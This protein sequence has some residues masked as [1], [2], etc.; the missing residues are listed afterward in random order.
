MNPFSRDGA[1]PAVDPTGATIHHGGSVFQILRPL[2][3][4]AIVAKIV[5][6]GAW[7]FAQRGA[8]LILFFGPDPFVLYALFVPSAQGLCRV[9]THFVTER[10]AV[11]LTIDDGPDENDTPQILDLLD[12]YR[13][14]ATFFVIGERAARR[15]DLLREIV[16]RGHQIGHHTHTHPAGS[17][18]C[19]SRHRLSVELDRT[20]DVLRDAGVRPEFFRAPVGIKHLFLGHALMLRQLQ[21]VGWTIRSGDCHSPSP[22]Q[23]VAGIT[24]RLRPG[25]ILLLHEG[26]SVPQPVRVKGIALLLEALA[27]RDLVCEIPEANQ[28]R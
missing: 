24:H 23:L 25:V 15:P 13:A 8:A 3:I 26:P 21:C 28:L 10:R 12:Q 11:W 5:A 17:F 16:R 14:R 4:T 18:W 20:L 6:V 7:A 2:V 19:A 1:T 27:T 9:F 22:E